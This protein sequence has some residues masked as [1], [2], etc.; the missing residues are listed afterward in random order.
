MKD[1][2]NNGRPIAPENV[3]TADRILIYNDKAEATQIT[4]IPGE[5]DLNGK[6]V[7]LLHRNPP[8][9]Q[10]VKVIFVIAYEGERFSRPIVCFSVEPG[11]WKSF[12]GAWS[13]VQSKIT[14]WEPAE[15][16]MKGDSAWDGSK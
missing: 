8:N 3:R 9:I 16:I 7:R 2:P 4:F 13:F 11:P 15:V 12:D 6:E 14:D 5:E 10:D 1:Y